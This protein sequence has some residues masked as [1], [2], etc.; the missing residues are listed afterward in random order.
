MWCIDAASALWA[1]SH[2][3]KGNDFIA[4]CEE[5]EQTPAASSAKQYSLKQLHSQ[6]SYQLQETS[7]SIHKKVFWPRTTVMLVPLKLTILQ[8]ICDI[9]ES[10][11]LM[12]KINDNSTKLVQKNDA[13]KWVQTEG[14][15]AGK[16]IT[17][18]ADWRYGQVHRDDG[19]ND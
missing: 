13:P 2:A 1:S 10:P 8:M 17:K 14:R 5:S 3:L 15:L 18:A 16:E 7:F 4:P 9:C 6:D 11:D 12:H 19:I